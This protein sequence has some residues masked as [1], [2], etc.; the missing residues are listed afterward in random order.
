MTIKKYC[1]N[2]IYIFMLIFMVNFIF[3]MWYKNLTTFLIC[4]F[5]DIIFAIAFIIDYKDI[6]KKC[7]Q[8]Q[9]E[10]DEYK[11]SNSKIIKECKN[12]QNKIK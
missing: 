5:V 1:K 11:E 10:I 7:L 2:N 8:C 4:I 12:I 9:K 3:C 6:K